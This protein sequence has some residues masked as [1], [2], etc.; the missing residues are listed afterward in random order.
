MTQ[1]KKTLSN[2]IPVLVAALVCDVAVADPSTGKKNLIGIFTRIN[3]GRFPTQR[4]VS[5]YAKLTDA[6]GY[7]Q[8][9]IKYVQVNSGKLLAEAKGELRAK[10]KLGSPDIIIHFPPLP[11]PEE[12][13]YEFQ[14]WVNNIF[15]GSAFIDAI[16]RKMNSQGD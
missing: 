7:Y 2:V 1:D 10:D 3:V 5:L 8:T 6:E 16:S 9:E 11:I 15:L 14:I 13:R 4:Q 12:G